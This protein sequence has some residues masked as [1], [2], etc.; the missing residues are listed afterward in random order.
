MWFAERFFRHARPLST[1]DGPV[2]EAYCRNMADPV[3]IAIAT[4]V[5]GKAAES[6]TDQVSRPVATIVARI[7]DRF[8]DRSAEREVVAVAER[9]PKRVEE[10]AEL[11][12][13]EMDSDPSFGAEIR[14]LWQQ[15]G[16]INIVHGNVGKV[17]QVRDVHGDLNV[18]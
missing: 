15:V 12:Q 7:R 13:A 11:L 3:T 1:T 6:L 14:A 10:L 8:R 2:S 9:E 18:N 17:V 5:A 4:A 16:T